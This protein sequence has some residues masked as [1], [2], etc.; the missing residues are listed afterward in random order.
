MGVLNG[1]DN[2]MTSVKT[3][4]IPPIIIMGVGASEKV[5]EESLKLGVKKCLLVTDKILMELGT[6]DTI[7]RAF[8]QSKIQFA[9]YD[10]V[11][12]EPTVEHVEKGLKV[13][14]E[15]MCDFRRRR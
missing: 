6:L 3:F 13:Y 5:G 4:Q 11:S 10:E 2:I 1:G 14:K 8:G 9:I 7:K 15:N 12:T